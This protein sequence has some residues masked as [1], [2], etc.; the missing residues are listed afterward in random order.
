MSEVSPEENSKKGVS[1][2][3]VLIGGAAGVAG[4]AAFAFLSGR[5][6]GGGSATADCV[7]TD[8]SASE[9]TLAVSNWPEYID[10]DD[11]DYV[12]TLTQFQEDSGLQVTYT[13][14]VNDNLEFFAKVRNQLGACQ[15]T[16][17]DLFVLTD[18]MAARMVQAGWTQKLDK[19]NV[20]NLDKNLISSLRAPTWDQN[21]DYSAPWQA[22]FTGIAYNKSL[23]PEVRTM[24][25]LLT[26]A[27]L[28]GKVTLLTE[29]E[30]TMGL[31]MLSDGADPENF[32]DDQYAAALDKL[33]KARAEGQIRAF[34]GNEYINDLAAGNI[35]AC[36]AWSGDVAAA[37]NEDLVFLPPDEGMMIWSDN[38]LVPVQGLHKANAEKWI[39]YYYD[40]KVAAKLAAYVWYVCPV[41]GARAEME[42]IDPSLV[43]NPLI[44]P[45]DE[46]LSKT[47]GF[48]AITDDERAVLE[49]EY[50]SVIG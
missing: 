37:D 27:D 40:P 2:R 12:S 5:G 11:G 7:T 23:V 43:D 20:P 8:L 17:R 10:V 18:W 41:E 4:I 24:D 13:P 38:M 21:R 15:P 3:G 48:K 35:A 16:G 26:R 6:G 9:P 36:V 1:R 42:S 45:T 30:D 28:K 14:D 50:T 31:L 19:A 32:T 29:M 49:K 44:F 47:H 25:E 22:G 34:T 33:S 39:N 46:Y